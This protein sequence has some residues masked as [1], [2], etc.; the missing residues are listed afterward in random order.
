[1]A[2]EATAAA[3]PQPAG[4]AS[5]SEL[6]VAVGREALPS[7]FAAL[8]AGFTIA[9]VGGR[10]AM[11]LLRVTSGSHVVGL[12]SDDGFIIGRV[13]SASFGLIAALTAGAVIVMAPL[14]MIARR[15]VPSRWRVPVFAVVLGLVGG[16]ALV[17]ADG[18]DFTLLTPR[19]LAV[20]LF[21]LI[22]AAF[23]AALEPLFQL[24]RRLTAHAP[25]WLFMVAALAST[26]G[27]LIFGPPGWLI[28]AA[29]V[30]AW[31]AGYGSHL[32]RLV[33]TPQWLWLGRIVLAAFAAIGT[34]ELT[35]DLAALF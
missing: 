27:V 19:W 8:V 29:V 2:S 18:I 12:E 14:Y 33:Q 24:G 32:A 11:F 30:I 10:L 23:A 7:L 31:A 22:P 28:G 16:G 6:L 9:G 1:M 17:H 26:T 13:T 15:W 20:G 34:F 5:R 3:I 21:V 4:N 25:A 35:R